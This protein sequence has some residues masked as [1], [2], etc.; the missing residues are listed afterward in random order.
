MAK[1]HTNLQA[2]L[3]KVFIIQIALISLVTLAGVFAAKA[4]LEDILVRAALEGE[5]EH[6]WLMRSENPD[7]PLPNTMNLQA[8]MAATDNL[9]SLPAPLR[10]LTPGLQRTQMQGQEPIVFQYAAHPENAARYRLTAL[11][12]R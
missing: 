3:I 7:F 9:Q 12:H 8:Y 1:A 4:T 11:S 2:K 5:A 6:F 10:D